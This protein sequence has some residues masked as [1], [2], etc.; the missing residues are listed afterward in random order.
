MLRFALDVVIVAFGFESSADVPALSD[1]I[2][3]IIKKVGAKF[4]RRNRGGL[5]ASLIFCMVVQEVIFCD[6]FV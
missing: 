4:G 3:D 1:N 5:M 2:G 6:F